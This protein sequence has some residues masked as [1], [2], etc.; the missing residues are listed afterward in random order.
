MTSFSTTPVVVFI[1]FA[2]VETLLS[3]SA[4][5]P[6]TDVVECYKMTMRMEMTL[7]KSIRHA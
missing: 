4:P 1:K 6:P 3:F 5:L 7:Y 2:L